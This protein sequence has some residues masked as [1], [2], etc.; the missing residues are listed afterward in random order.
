MFERHFGLR[1]NPFSAG[2][3]LKFLYPSREH[4]EARAHL[5]YGIEN[6][7]PFLLITGEVGT[8]KT[9]SLYDALA[10]WGPQ[11]TVALITN[12]ALTR[13]E[14]LE[15]ICLRFGVSVPPGASKPQALVQLER[16]LLAVTGR[17]EHA[18]LILDEAQN[19]STELLE[20]IRLLSNL[21]AHGDKLLQIFLVGQP[22]LEAKLSRPDLRQL[23]QRITVQYRLNPLSPEETAGYIHHRISVAGG[24]AWIVFPPE[25]CREVYHLTHGIP[26]EINTL[27]SAAMIAAYAEGAPSVRP[28]HVASVASEAE[29]RS[30]VPEGGA[31]GAPAGRV[32]PPADA[33][34]APATARPP[35]LRPPA[36]HP[37]PPAA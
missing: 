22:E 4:Q 25:S 12:S 9:T 28:E 19:L 16:Y 33:A 13:Q 35:A 20:E 37:E 24:N 31:T 21:E 18:V 1:E 27:A 6:R 8:G 11:V 30:V 34:R 36:L 17:A 26:R 15:E 7:E 32:T 10:E 23:R 5:R 3:Q 14:L 29:F 2:H